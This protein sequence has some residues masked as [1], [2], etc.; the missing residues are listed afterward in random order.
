MNNKK[1][2]KY[3]EKLIGMIESED[4]VDQID[5]FGAFL[6]TLELLRLEQ[7]RDTRLAIAE[8]LIDHFGAFFETLES[9]RLEQDRDIRLAI[10]ER[11]SEIAEDVVLTAGHAYSIALNARAL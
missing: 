6:E 4:K 1:L 7:D 3:V 11:L 8:K 10:A 5:R 2:C 9:L